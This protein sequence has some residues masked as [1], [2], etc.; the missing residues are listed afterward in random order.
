MYL[1]DFLN[2]SD[3]RLISEPLFQMF[4]CALK[5][6]A[7]PRK[8]FRMFEPA[9]AAPQAAVATTSVVARAYAAFDHLSLATHSGF[10]KANFVKMTLLFW[11]L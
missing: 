6:K 11:C 2:L 8:T 10:C 4:Y 5:K 1:G 3:Y 7:F 9:A